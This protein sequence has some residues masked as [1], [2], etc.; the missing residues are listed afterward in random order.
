MHFHEGTRK[1]WT[2]SEKDELKQY[3][4][5][6]FSGRKK[7]TCPSGAECKQA[8][9]QSR[10]NGGCLH[11]RSWD[12]I[13][14]KVNHLLRKRCMNNP[15][16]KKT[17]NNPLCKK[18]VNNPLCKKTVNNPLC[19]KEANRSILLCSMH[20]EKRKKLNF[21]ECKRKHTPWTQPEMNEL[22]RYFEDFFSR[23]EK[24]TCPSKADCDRAIYLSKENGGCLHLRPWAVIKKKVN[25]V[26]LQ[27]NASDD[28]KECA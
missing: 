14:K 17:V 21:N 1:K 28:K 7:K 26:L 23:K 20:E 3:F 25:N 15:L 6:Y 5:E 13:K 10:E 11:L 22:K 19:E 24:K 18:T 2:R 16:C 9:E 4:E 12:T 27:K 8:I